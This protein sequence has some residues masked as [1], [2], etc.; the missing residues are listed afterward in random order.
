MNHEES[1][2]LSGLAKSIPIIAAAIT[3][4]VPIYVAV[5][6]LLAP[7]SAVMADEPQMIT[8]MAGV[9]AVLSVGNLVASALLVSSRRRS[10]ARLSDPRERLA[11][12]RVAVIIAFALREA[13]AIF[14]LVLSLLS[15][16]PGWAVGLGAVALLSMLAG[17]PRRSD[18]ARLASAVPPIG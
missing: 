15:G 14:G 8:L 17:W 7:T 3:V 1:K 11:G 16:D 12:Y 5:A 4:T 2:G 10:L 9:L 6:W 13:V 18:I